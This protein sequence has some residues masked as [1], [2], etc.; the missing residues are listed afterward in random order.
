M[1]EWSKRGTASALQEPSHG[2][3]ERAC[4]D[5]AL[6]L[7]LALPLELVAARGGVLTDQ[8]TTP[9]MENTV[10]RSREG[11]NNYDCECALSNAIDGS[12]ARCT[13]CDGSMARVV[14]HDVLKR[15]SDKQCGVKC[16]GL[17]R[18]I[19]KIIKCA[20]R[21]H[22]PTPSTPCESRKCCMYVCVCVCE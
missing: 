11:F 19:D 22:H 13:L 10:V 7:V 21:Q 4:F 1:D 14:Q 16:R 5:L 2:R 18:I 3:R 15:R 6:V 20:H 12:Y 8:C 17:A 9:A